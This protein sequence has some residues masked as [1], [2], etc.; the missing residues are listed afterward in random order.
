MNRK[1]RPTRKICRVDEK[2]LNRKMYTVCITGSLVRKS[3]QVVR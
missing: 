1:Y 3:A 2:R